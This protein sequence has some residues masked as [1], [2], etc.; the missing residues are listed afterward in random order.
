TSQ[1][2]I[3][4][5]KD[6]SSTW[7]G[8]TEGREQDTSHR[9][10]ESTGGQKNETA[11]LHE[12]GRRQAASLACAALASCLPRD[13]L[14]ARS[15]GCRPCAGWH[16]PVRTDR[17]CWHDWQQQGGRRHYPMPARPVRNGNATC[18][19]GQSRSH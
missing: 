1:T 15:I 19:P 10:R 13:I 6:S 14:S 12:Q 16:W 18:G 3:T 7:W 17:P 11:K 5:R 9:C 8:G 4:T 2:S